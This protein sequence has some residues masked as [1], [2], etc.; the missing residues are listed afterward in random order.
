MTGNGGVDYYLG[1]KIEEAGQDF[2]YGG[3]T[4][5]YIQAG[6]II[7]PVKKGNISLTAGPTMGIYKG[8]SD[9]G[10]G[11]NL[12]GAYL[13]QGFMENKIMIGPG[14]TY[15]KHAQADALWTAAIRVSYRF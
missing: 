5:L 1:K 9:F 2:R 4:Y 3:Y 12:F 15:K 10:W 7:N 11:V 6:I 13:L 8:N 14:V